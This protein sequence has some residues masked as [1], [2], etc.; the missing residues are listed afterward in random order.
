MFTESAE[1]IQPPYPDGPVTNHSPFPYSA[2]SMSTLEGKPHGSKK[3]AFLFVS[4]LKST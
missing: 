3:F 2:I 4:K 1:F